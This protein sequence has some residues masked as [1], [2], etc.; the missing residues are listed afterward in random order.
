M[1]AVLGKF[2]ER[3]TLTLANKYTAD[4]RVQGC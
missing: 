4:E 1:A 2:A 3:A